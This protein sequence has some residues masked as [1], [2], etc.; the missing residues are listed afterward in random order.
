M[1]DRRQGS[2]T[3]LVRPPDGARLRSGLEKLETYTVHAERLGLKL[4]SDDLRID[5]VGAGQD[6]ATLIEEFC[7]EYYGS[8]PSVPVI[9]TILARRWQPSAP[10]L[11]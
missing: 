2:G 7:L 1:L 4:D 9:A 10:P 3:F 8:A 5:A 11:R 6:E